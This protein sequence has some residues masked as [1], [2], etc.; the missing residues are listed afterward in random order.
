VALGLQQVSDVA[1][2]PAAMP[3]A[4]NEH[5][6]FARSALRHRL[7]VAERGGAGAK[8][9]ARD[10][11][12]ACHSVQVAIHVGHSIPPIIFGEAATL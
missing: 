5:E 7:R 2:A 10:G 6:G 4:V 11:G 12:A 1:P 8:R 9:C 3:G